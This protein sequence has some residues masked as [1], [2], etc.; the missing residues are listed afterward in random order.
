MLADEHFSLVR[1]SPLFA[2]IE[3]QLMYGLR[4]GLQWVSLAQGE[5][6][7]R[8][9]E[10]VDSLYVVVD[11]RLE[12]LQ[13]NDDGEERAIADVEAGATVGE[14]KIIGGGKR[15]A[16]IRAGV[17]SSLIRVTKEAFDAFLA[18]D[19]HV[20]AQISQI[21]L[22]RLYRDQLV[23]VLPNLFGELDSNALQRLEAQ[24]TWVHLPRGEVLF[25]QGDTSDSFY[26]LISG[27][28]QVMVADAAGRYD[29]PGQV[30][31]G[32]SVG[33]MGAFT[34]EPR[35]ASLV[36]VRD[37]ELARFSK[38]QFD[39][40][41]REF[42]QLM[43]H[44]TQLLI[45]R[46]TRVQQSRPPLSSNITL[47]PASDDVDLEGFA[48]RIHGELARMDTSLCLTSGLVD[49]MLGADGISQAD[50][51]TPNDLRLRAWINE[52]EK[53]YRFLVFL[54]DREAT[55]WSTRCIREADEL[56]H[57]GHAFGDPC[58][59]AVEQEVIRQQ[60]A[61]STTWQRS[62]VLLYPR[63]VLQPS[64]TLAWLDRRRVQR[65]FHVRDPSDY[66]RVAR[67]AA[68]R[69]VGVVLS[70]GGARGFAHVG[71]LRAIEEAGVPIDV[72]AGVS[73]GAALA[74]LYAYSEHFYD[75]IPFFKKQLKGLLND[76]TLPIVSLSR[77]RRLNR[78]MQRLFGDT[79]LEDL[80][81]PCILVSSNLT[82]GK[83]VVHRTGE[84]WRAARASGS[85]P[86]IVTPVV[87]DGNLLFDGCLLNN[88]PMD[89]MRTEVGTGAV[90]AV[91]VVPPV[92]LQVADS[93][94]DCPS[95][96]RILWSWLNPFVEN[97][98]LPDIISIVQR[99]GQIGCVQA[100]Q[101]LIDDEVADLYLQPPV[102]QFEI[103]DFSVVDETSEIGYEFA[104][105]RVADWWREYQTKLDRHRRVS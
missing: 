37:C 75:S 89:V 82:R 70:G 43:A 52:Q 94:F 61:N 13:P 79:R 8:I 76:F 47:V 10:P 16:T 34:G 101:Q 7:F 67:F 32:E 102:E 23:Q 46:L 105:Q 14:M 18:S 73:M 71:V 5:V 100:R 50:E 26:I 21:I 60:E 48:E 72:I 74:A 25:G 81:R 51:G 56:I 27:R 97:I 59:T 65:H 38:E 33:E 54:T 1:S 29:F 49:S 3:A 63:S 66:G 86:G 53:H 99:A 42:P 40:L 15:S 39:V 91:D 78:R 2:G 30:A 35:S 62:L 24:M 96:W 87:E 104:R 84:V 19:P 80:W 55:G 68:G 20:L 4:D 17:T 83:V 41:V 31:Q 64:G 103:L 57:V 93:P 12:V 92:D 88:L 45:R 77:G 85:L 69:A 36:A 95:G 9:G 11:G 98:Q 58:L 6:L 22:P 90:V 44:V 28:L